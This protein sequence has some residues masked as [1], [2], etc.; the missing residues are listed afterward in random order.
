MRFLWIL[1]AIAGAW[2]VASSAP[3]GGLL[4]SGHGA[5]GWISELLLG[6]AAITYSFYRFRWK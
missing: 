6:I 2:L 5:G 3:E 1:L 4:P